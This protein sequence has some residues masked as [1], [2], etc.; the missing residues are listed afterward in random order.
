M[1]EIKRN[2]EIAGQLVKEPLPVN[3]TQIQYR[4]DTIPGGISTNLSSACSPPPPPA[5]I[6]MT[7]LHVFHT[8]ALGSSQLP[9]LHTMVVPHSTHREQGNTLR[10]LRQ[11]RI[12]V[13][14]GT[15]L[16]RVQNLQEGSSWVTL[17][18]LLLERERKRERGG[19]LTPWSVF[20]TEL[21]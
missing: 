12:L 1:R 9:P 15:V 20:F 7:Q 10:S 11:G 13:S 2:V 4:E 16:L 21:D 5:S 6:M 14:E 19:E 8:L 3:V 17:E 18:T